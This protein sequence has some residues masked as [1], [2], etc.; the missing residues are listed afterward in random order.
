VR[1]TEQDLALLDAIQRKTGI[2]SRTEI[3]RR[4]IRALAQQEDADL[5]PHAGA[6]AR[7]RA[8]RG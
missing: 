8:R 5:Q 4:A 3:L 2:V 1:F 6:A 7:V